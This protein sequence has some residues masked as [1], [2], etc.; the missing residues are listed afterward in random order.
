MRL[1]GFKGLDLM[2]ISLNTRGGPGD[3]AGQR[4][5]QRW[6]HQCCFL[7]S[8]RHYSGS[9]FAGLRSVAALGSRKRTA[10][11]LVESRGDLASA[12]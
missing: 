1:G 3:R 2:N 11:A 5:L 7:Y 12:G 10:A 8:P 6:S 4:L 9:Y